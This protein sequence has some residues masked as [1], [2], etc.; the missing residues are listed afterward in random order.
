VHGPQAVAVLLDGEVRD[1]PDHLAQEVDHR[2]DIEEL[3]LQLGGPQVHDL[4]SRPGGI[5]PRQFRRSRAFTQPLRAEEEV[6]DL[7]AAVRTDLLGEIR[8][9]GRQDA[10]DLGPVGHHRMPAGHQVEGALSER[11]W[12]LVLVGDH[13]HALAEQVLLGTRDVRRPGLGGDHGLGGPLRHSRQHLA[14]ARLDVQRQ[15]GLADFLAHE[16]L[17]PPGRPF[18][19]GATVQPGKVPPSHVDRIGLRDES[20]EARHP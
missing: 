11:Q 12:R 19:G 20:L 16:P 4:Q 10:G 5:D 18:L 13:D 17:I 6:V 3:H 15:F 2:P 14:A 8:A 1:E 9:A 7:V